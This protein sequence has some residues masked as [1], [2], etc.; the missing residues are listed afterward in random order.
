M[1]FGFIVGFALCKRRWNW[2][3]FPVAYDRNNSRREAVKGRLIICR[4][5]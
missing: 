2:K 5:L 1:K 4:H 3:D